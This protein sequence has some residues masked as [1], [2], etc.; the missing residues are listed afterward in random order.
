MK[1]SFAASTSPAVRATCS[2][3]VSRSR[4]RGHL[5]HV[6]HRADL[7]RHLLLDVVALVEHERDVRA[8]PEAAAPHD[9]NHDPEE[10]ERVGGTDDEVVVRVEA[11]VEVERAELSQA[12]Q[13]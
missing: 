10:L 4:A 1:T 3:S 13:L 12:E 6:E 5:L 11:A 7:T 8:C 9:L 2:A